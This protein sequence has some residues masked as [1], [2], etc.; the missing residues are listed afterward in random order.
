MSV[1]GVRVRAPGCGGHGADWVLRRAPC[2]LCQRQVRPGVTAG[3]PS[4]QRELTVN[5][6]ALPTGVRI[7]HLPQRPHTSG[8]PVTETR[9]L[10]FGAGLAIERQTDSLRWIAPDDFAQATLGG[11]FV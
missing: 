4:G 6:P 5:Q 2:R 1:D 8:F 3:C 7:P 9:W 10:L 11:E